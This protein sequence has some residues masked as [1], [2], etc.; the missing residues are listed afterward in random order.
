MTQHDAP[1][2]PPSVEAPAE[3]QPLEYR[4]PGPHSSVPSDS[5]TWFGY[6]G[7]GIALFSLLIGVA[8]IV[9]AIVW[10]IGWTR[11]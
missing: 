2:D 7:L 3:A 1:N 8:G 4:S 5:P 11:S 6:I 10:F 9:F